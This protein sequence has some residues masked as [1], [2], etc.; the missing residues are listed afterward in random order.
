MFIYKYGGVF[1]RKKSFDTDS[2]KAAL[3]GIF[4]WFAVL[5]IFALLTSALAVKIHISEKHTAYISSALTF[6][7]SAA[8][9]YTMR[10][11]KT[12]F[13]YLAALSAALIILAL[14]M[15]FIISSENM[16]SGGIL[17]VAS[18][19]LCGV[20]AGSLIQPKKKRREKIKL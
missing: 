1:L 11:R 2:I 12:K 4:I 19:T 5:L 6:F 13:F 17:S 8:A 15:G 18:F 9:G 14:L 16:C 3:R 10:K 20:F 7:S